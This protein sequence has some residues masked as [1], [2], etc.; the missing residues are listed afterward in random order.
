LSRQIFFQKFF[1]PF[2][3]EYFLLEFLFFWSIIDKN[4]LTHPSPLWGE[5]KG[6]GTEGGGIDETRKV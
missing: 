2:D 3:C 5:D 1:T 4:T 6:E